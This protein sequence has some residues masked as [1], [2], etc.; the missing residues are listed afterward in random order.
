MQAPLTFI[1]GNCVF[2]RGLDDAWAAF[3]VEVSSYAWLSDEAKRARFL[4]LIGALEAIEADVQILRV[5]RRWQPERYA[6][7]LREQSA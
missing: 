6:R 1:Y 7:S 5:C 2:A 3:A 4:A